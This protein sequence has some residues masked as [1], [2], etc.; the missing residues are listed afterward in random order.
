MQ[1]GEKK[2]FSD[3]PMEDVRQL[4][5]ICLEANKYENEICKILKEL[6]EGKQKV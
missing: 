3:L 4:S 1:E 6:N 5:D 2:G